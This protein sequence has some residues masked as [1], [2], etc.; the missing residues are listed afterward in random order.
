MDQAS[1]PYN[2]GQALGDVRVKTLRWEPH[3]QISFGWEETHG[4]SG[5]RRLVLE[6]FKQQQ[7]PD[8]DRENEADSVELA[9]K[10]VTLFRGLAARINYL[11][12]DRSDI[13]F[14]SKEVCREMCKPTRD[15]L[16]KLMNFG[17]ISHDQTSLDLEIW[18]SA[19]A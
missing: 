2:V 15:S 6:A 5:E 8:R 13:Q 18:L 1:L 11:A 19:L 12:L 7:S 16:S 4:Q 10:D 17:S 9:G 14:A 3:W